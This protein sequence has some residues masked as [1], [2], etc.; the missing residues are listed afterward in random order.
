[1]EHGTLAGNSSINDRIYSCLATLDPRDVPAFFRKFRRGG[2]D[3]ER[4]HTFRELLLGSHLRQRGWAVR[5]EQHLAG[6]TPDWLIPAGASGPSEIVD[7]VTLHQRRS[8]DVEIGATISAGQIWSGWVTIPPDHILSKLDQKVGSYRRLASLHAL[9]YTVALF[10]EFTASVD[11][12][13]VS[14][15]LY[16]HHGACSRRLPSSQG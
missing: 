4:F 2:G 12:E 7:V 11:P 3:D 8:T 5:Y 1:M 15:V 6:K 9:P 14:H 13:E 10:G 16:E